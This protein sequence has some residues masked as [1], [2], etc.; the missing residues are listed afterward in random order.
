[1]FIESNAEID[2][3]ISDDKQVKIADLEA[4]SNAKVTS[5]GLELL[6]DLSRLRVN[7]AANGF[8]LET[9][10]SAFRSLAVF[11]S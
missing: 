5:S 4:G 9:L 8:N 6:D 1:M 11:S 10:F 7:S 2:D 3:V